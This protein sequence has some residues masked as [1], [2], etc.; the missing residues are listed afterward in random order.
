MSGSFAFAS[1]LVAPNS[2]IIEI[3]SFW[4][5]VAVPVGSFCHTVC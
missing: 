4:N 3:K 1:V 5:S 2:A